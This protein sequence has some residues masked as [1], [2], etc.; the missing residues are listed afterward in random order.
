MV[1]QGQDVEGLDTT[2]KIPDLASAK[3][4]GRSAKHTRAIFIRQD[5]ARRGGIVDPR[6]IRKSKDEI[7]K[8]F[9]TSGS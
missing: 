7:R 9:V 3:L 6:I 5:D 4:D 8:G 1:F 2:Y